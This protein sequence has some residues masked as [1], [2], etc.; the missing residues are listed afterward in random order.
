MSDK[1]EKVIR[2]VIGGRQ[3]DTTTPS[4][5]TADSSHKELWQMTK[6]E[7]E[8]R[9]GQ[10]RLNTTVTGRFS[11]HKSAV[12]IALNKG[13]PVPQEVLADYPA[14]TGS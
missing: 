13:L 5:P 10:L 6:S 2:P 8:Q 12:E 4:K 14:L 9:H 11:P 3:I 1:I 7:Y